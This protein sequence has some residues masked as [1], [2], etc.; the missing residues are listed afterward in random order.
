VVREVLLTA[1]LVTWAVATLPAQRSA[2]AQ[3][4]AS[5]VTTAV[6]C[7]ADLG[8]GVKSR[9]QFCDVIVATTGAGSVSMD[10]PAH[11]GAATLRFDLHN[12]FT[13]P[14]A[15]VPPSVAFMRHAA[16][17]AVVGP[18]GTVID[19]AGVVHEYRTTDDLFDRIGGGG[20][21]GGVKAV[22]PGPAEAVRVTIPPG[23]SSIGI[24]GTRLH[25]L[26][27]AGDE[28]F[29][30]PGRPVAIVSNLRIE[31]TPR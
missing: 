14:A 2:A 16:L 7:A 4:L 17:V 9:R 5:T 13:V 1:G 26:T 20:R 24:V 31:Y 27:R 12:R 25:V 28:T 21:A 19:R 3:R 11:T 6:A 30:S 10:I 23:V 8:A 18:T 15:I 29:D 22:A